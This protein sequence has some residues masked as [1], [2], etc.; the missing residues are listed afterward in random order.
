[1]SLKLTLFTIKK[2]KFCQTKFHNWSN[3]EKKNFIEI[4]SMKIYENFIEITSM[5]I[6]AAKKTKGNYLSLDFICFC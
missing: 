3:F 2:K 1:M 5:K 4:T 6:Y